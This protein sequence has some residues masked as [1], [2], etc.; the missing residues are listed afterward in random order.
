MAEVWRLVETMRDEAYEAQRVSSL[1]TLPA[2]LE[3]ELGQFDPERHVGHRAAGCRAA[4]DAA[5]DR[6]GAGPAGASVPPSLMLKVPSALKTS[7]AS[8]Q[9]LVGSPGSD[10][11]LAKVV[12]GR[13]EAER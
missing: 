3:I 4:E 7:D 9:G 13:G 11:L 6:P 5:R 2:L 1:T 8:A 12:V 10:Q